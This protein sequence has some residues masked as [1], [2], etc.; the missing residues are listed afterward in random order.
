[1]AD[2]S[3]FEKL[4]LENLFGMS[5]GYVLNF[6]N[7]TFK[8]FFAENLGIDIYSSKYDYDSGSK[9]NRLRAFWMR[10]NNAI[11]GKSIFQ[12]LNCQILENSIASWVK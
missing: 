2:L 7:R 6:S 1:M 10:E 9:A 3:S 4:K 11:V 8:E 5:S 12:L